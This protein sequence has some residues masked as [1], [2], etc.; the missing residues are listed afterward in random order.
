MSIT[1]WLI[2][3]ERGVSSNAIAEAAFGNRT[4]TRLCHPLDPADLRRCL[5]LLRECPEARRGI[6]KLAELYPQWERLEANW[7]RL[8]RYL[9]S[10]IGAEL[11]ARGRAPKTYELM[12]SL[13]H[14]DLND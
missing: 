13:L 3:G 1:N 6:Q 8:E 9:I 5:L 10:E 11:P 2:N 4:E 12:Q 7:E 14:P